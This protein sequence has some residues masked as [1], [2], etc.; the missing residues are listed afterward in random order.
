MGSLEGTGS[1]GKEFDLLTACPMG[2]SG[3]VVQEAVGPQ[4]PNSEG[5][6][7]Q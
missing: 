7:W 5:H 6:K 1:W 2:Q 4:R 3:P